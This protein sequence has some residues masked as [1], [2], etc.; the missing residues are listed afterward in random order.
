MEPRFQTR[1]QEM[2]AQ[3][4]VSVAFVQDLL[5]R[6]DRFLEPFVASLREPD[7]RRHATEYLTGL[8]SNLKRKTGEGIAYLLDQDRKPLQDFIGQAPWEHQPLL[9]TLAA[10]VGQ[11]L[12]EPDGVI[13]FDPSAFPKKGTKSVG[14]TRQWC[15]RNGKV[16]N[17]QVGVYMAYVSRK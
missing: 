10:Q 12:G 15:G 16:D 9:A 2:L 11:R 3:T 8:L 4:E 1:L 7:Q 17:S 5:P 13:V 14:V 6:L